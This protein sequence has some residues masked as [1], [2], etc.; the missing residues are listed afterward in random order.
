MRGP[1]RPT[2]HAERE[3]AGEVD[4]QVPSGKSLGS[5]GGHGGV[6]PEPRHGAERAEERDARPR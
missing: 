2:Q 6:D 5:A 3:R 4:D 1:R